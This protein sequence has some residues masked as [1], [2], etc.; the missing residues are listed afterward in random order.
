MNI[1]ILQNIL[2]TALL[3][4]QIKG[5]IDGHNHKKSGYKENNKI[6]F[7]VELK[8][9]SIIF[10]D[11]RT[12]KDFCV[13]ENCDVEPKQV[14]LNP[15]IMNGFKLKFNLLGEIIENESYKT[16]QYYSDVLTE[17]DGDNTTI[18]SISDSYVKAFFQGKQAVDILR[19]ELRLKCQDYNY[20]I[21]CNINNKNPQFKIVD[22]HQLYNTVAGGG[23]GYGITVH[24]SYNNAL[25]NKN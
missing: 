12:A 2:K 7:L 9:S 13:E 15:R 23:L 19:N 10:D 5:Y 17:R 24:Q 21:L 1:F 3:V 8:G 4:F 11:Y 20:Y 22:K 16:V 14:T 25:K 18:T 6:G